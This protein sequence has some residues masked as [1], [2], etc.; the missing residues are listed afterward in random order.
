MSAE[1]IDLS[2]ACVD[3]GRL[4]TI[5][6]Y[7]YFTIE[8]DRDSD[9]VLAVTLI[10]PQ[11]EGMVRWIAEHLRLRFTPQS[12]K[13][14]VFTAGPTAVV[15]RPVDGGYHILIRPLRP[16][17]AISGT[18][19]EVGIDG[20]CWRVLAQYD[21]FATYASKVIQP[22]RSLIKAQ[23]AK[24]RVRYAPRFQPQVQST[25]LTV[26]I[27]TDWLLADWLRG[28]VAI[29]LCLKDGKVL[30]E[31]ICSSEQYLLRSKPEG[32]DT[33]KF[34]AVFPGFV[35]GDDVTELHLVLPISPTNNFIHRLL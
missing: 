12:H 15:P 32:Q 9:F 10:A 6:A 22:D 34:Q 26:E 16:L 13:E 21:R 17:F 8:H 35:R 31:D 3:V 29:R 24:M 11:K 18:K 33:W 28:N 7:R 19:V 27:E 5:S 1:V 30:E 25:L 4:N 14:Q 20:K 2:E 23:V